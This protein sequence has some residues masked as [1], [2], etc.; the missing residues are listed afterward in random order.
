MKK[1]TRNRFVFWGAFV[2][3]FAVAGMVANAWYRSALAPMPGGEPFY[4]RYEESTSFDTVV[5]Q[6]YEKKVVRDVG[7]FRLYCFVNRLARTSVTGTLQFRPGMD[8]RQIYSATRKKIEQQIRIPEG[9]WIARTA[10]ILEE[11][12]VCTAAEYESEASNPQAY[13]EYVSFK[14]P[15]KSLEGYL[16]PDTYDFPP[17]LGAREVIKRQLRTFE[18]KVYEPTKEMGGS[19][20][21]LYRALIVASMVELEAAQQ[22]ERPKIAGVIENRVS[23]NQ[24]LEIDATVLYAL[25]D[26]RVLGPGEVRKVESPYNTYLNPGLPPGPIGSPAWRSVEAALNPEAHEYFYYV[27]RPNRYHYFS[28]SYRGHRTNINKARAEFKQEQS[29]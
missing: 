27:A 24:N 16:Y 18:K 6:L 22:E 11:K 20:D 1:R 9:W 28:E 3:T 26:W 5:E 17:L 2:A 4:V 23:S 10:K 8:P 12:G 29:A 15:E 14:L 7:A 19:E 21:V 13:A 25:Q